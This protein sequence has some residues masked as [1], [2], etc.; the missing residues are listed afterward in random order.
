MIAVRN[1]RFVDGKG[2][3]Y[4]DRMPL[5]LSL[6]RPVTGFELPGL[7]ERQADSDQ[8]SAGG[9][10]ISVLPGLEGGDVGCR[11]NGAIDEAKERVRACSRIESCLSARRADRPAVLGL[12]TGETGASIGSK[13]LE[14]CITACPRYAARL[15][16]RD[17]PAVIRIG[18]KFQDHARGRMNVCLRL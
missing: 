6:A 12:M 4:M 3:R 7:R 2:R 8:A 9:Q 11:T 5:F 14:E 17:P 13:I 16:C 10:S 15:V 1:G 18:A